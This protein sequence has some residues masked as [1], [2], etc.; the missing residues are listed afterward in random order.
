MFGPGHRVLCLSGDGGDMSDNYQ[1]VY[2]AVRS[3]ISNG[4]IGSAVENYLYQ[5]SIPHSWQM[6]CEEWR[7]AA[8]QHALPHVLMR[9]SISIDGNMHCALYGDNLQDGIAGFGETVATAMS[10][11]ISMYDLEI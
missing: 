2:D 9:P 5:S 11:C 8:S 10:D 6:A 4:D 1:A 7:W 3:K